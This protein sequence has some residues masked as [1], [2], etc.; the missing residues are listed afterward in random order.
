MSTVYKASDPNL[1]RT[2]AIK[3]IHPHLSDNPQFVRRFEQ[4]AAAVARLRHPNIVQVYDFSQQQGV[5]YI[6]MEFVPGETLEQR[7]ESL[8]KA[9]LRLPLEETLR[10]MLALCDAVAYAH[11]QNMIHRDLKPSNVIINLVG[12]VILTDFGVAKLVGGRSLTETGATIGTASYMS[13]EQVTG[14]PVDHR[15]DIYALGVM[16][17]EMAAG[18]PPFEGS[19]PLTVMMAHVNEPVPD[20][21]LTN[22]N[23]PDS[24]VAVL[25]KALAKKPVHRFQSALEM[26]TA[27]QVIGQQMIGT[28]SRHALRSTGGSAR[29]TS[30][31][32]TLPVGGQPVSGTQLVTPRPPERATAPALAESAA[33]R[34]K[35]RS[36]APLYA[37]VAAIGVLLLLLLVAGAFLLVPRFFRTLP[38]SAGMVRVPAGAYT[39]GLEGDG[40]NY[41]AVRQVELDEFW[42]DRY[43]V[44]NG[45]YAEYVAETDGPR[46]S[47]WDGGSAPAGQ[48][49]YPV[50]GAS[51]AMASAYCEWANKRLPTEAE[52][53]VAARGAAGL[54]FPWGN[55]AG[56]VRLPQGS[57]YP[58]GTVPA[59]RSQ[60]GLFD[61]AGNVWE[62]VDEPYEAVPNGQFVLRGGAHDFLKD[63]AYRLV[64]DPT[65]PTMFATAG[66]RCAADEV[67]VVPD[68]T[69]LVSD[70]FANPQSGWPEM[71]EGSTLFGYHPPSYYHVQSGEANHVTTVFYGETFKDISVE[72]AVLVDST[73]S[74]DGNFRYGLAYGQPEGALY[75]FTV[76]PRA[77]AWQVLRSTPD[78]LEE[79]LQGPA[80]GLQGLSGITDT[81]RVDAA[82]GALTFAINHQVVVQVTPD[83]G[84]PA[85]DVGFYVETFDETRAHV[86]Y[87]SLAIQ[88][89]VSGA[90]VNALLSDDFANPASGWPEVSEGSTLSGY[91]PPDYY[92]VQSEEPNH[93]ST[94]FY[95]Q[96]FGD[97]TMESLVFVDSTDTQDGDFYYGLAVR[98][99]GESYYAFLV[100]PRAGAWQVLKSSA[101]GQQLLAE[102]AATLNGLAGRDLLRVDAQGPELVFHINGQAVAHVSD[103]EYTSG[104]VGFVVET[105]DETRA[106]IHYESLLVTEVAMDLEAAPTAVSTGPTPGSETPPTP[107]PTAE[108]TTASVET[109]TPETPASPSQGMV[110]VAAGAYT[111]GA[112]GSPV[113]L[114]EFWI[115]AYEVSNV[116]YARF[117][118]ENGGDAP[119]TW[120]GGNI[121]AGLED[122]P[123]EGLTWNQA[124]AYCGWAG[125]RLPTET[126]W[127]AAARGPQ[128]W[129]YPWGNERS[130]VPL[131]TS[132]TYTVGAIPANR[133]FFGAFDMAG[134]VW[135]WVDQPYLV[136][137]EGQQVLRGGANNFQNDMTFRA[138]GDPNSNIMFTNAGIRCAASQVAVELEG[139][140]LLTDNFADL[141]SGWWQAA[142]PV[143]PYFY[144][145]HPT[146]FYHVQV[147]AP[148]DCL[149]VYHD[150]TLDNFMAEVDVF[151]AATNTENGNFRYG[152]MVRETDSDFYA[153]V[154]APR[155]Q[156][157]QVLKSA[158]EGLLL[159]DEGQQTTIRGAGQEVKDRLFV[160]ANGPELT[161]FVNGALVSRVYDADYSSGHV[162]FMV[163]T[164]DETYAHVHYD[165]I[166]VWSLPPGAA[167]PAGAP[168]ANP[169]YPVNAPICRGT[170]SADN[171][172]LSFISYQIKPGDTL[173]EIA[174]EFGVTVEDILGANGRTIETPSF[175]RAGQ[176]I[177][178]PQP[179]G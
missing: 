27:L 146:D 75:V 158:P 46:P 19:S 82:N 43:E 56:L 42:I 120:A 171:L 15:A 144:G 143:G 103:S 121:P 127:E 58:V 165:T 40:S 142:A 117:L 55:E 174:Q 49:D 89:L 47:T 137:P 72:T 59:N 23:I 67:E 10:T 78:G 45:Q 141:N 26:A 124:A 155:S 20:I 35:R 2:V 123:V 69:L 152:L 131:P 54:L 139:A 64:G 85:G 84:L 60:F 97:F 166:T 13:P 83:S 11:E 154:I 34:A 41:A 68:E 105:V 7:L 112:A 44:S 138:V 129:L 4:E 126:E 148:G 116:Q 136:V 175:I 86:H 53:E 30:D 113:T 167:A 33:P 150:V 37:A 106:H 52:W 118:A 8:R 79:L 61:A 169:Q 62:W 164:L 70:N 32:D 22:S 179:E 140:V 88:Q 76:S 81:L 108:P 91:H 96:E 77:G 128:G 156:S 71:R 93:R 80:E 176:T 63:M 31:V 36:R 161:F 178:I 1:Q 115:D 149:S 151:I 162:G 92:H 145:Y 5:H 132:G 73:D 12:Q 48:A 173:I 17:Y 66:F 147:S 134:N 104:Q 110:R 74:Q 172:L 65:V 107:E 38:A 125:K 3:M 111:V 160:I 135:E 102:G 39:V 109:P 90:A 159:M 29:V 9:N 18:K 98:R 57:S 153:F 28:A 87:D 99:N 25:G 157:W 94:A 130:A 114:S 133:S 163:E 122:H 6:V 16:L 24:L 14:E 21:R 168:P 177:V 95:D 50:Q 119:A 101:T 100:S 170:V 51:W